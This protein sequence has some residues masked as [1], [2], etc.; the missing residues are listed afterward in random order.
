M[1]AVFDNIIPDTATNADTTTAGTTA[2][3]MSNQE[4]LTNVSCL[5]CCREL[6]ISSLTTLRI[7]PEDTAITLPRTSLPLK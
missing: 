7:K 6:I 1:T 3:G 2:M 5:S 4:L